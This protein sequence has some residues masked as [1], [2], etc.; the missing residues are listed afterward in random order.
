MFYALE[1]HKRRD[2]LDG[3]FE[4]LH[5]SFNSDPG[6]IHM[7][8]NMGEDLRLQTELADSLAI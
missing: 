6:I 5:T 4:R 2:M 8:P 1:R 7:A 3:T